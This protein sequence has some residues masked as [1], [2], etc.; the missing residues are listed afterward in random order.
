[1]EQLFRKYINGECTPNEEE[2]VLGKLG[3]KAPTGELYQFLSK[4]WIEIEGKQF[5]SDMDFDSVLD[6]IHHSINLKEADDQKSK[7]TLLNRFYNWTR[8]AAASIIILMA[9]VGVWY[10]GHTGMFQEEVFY[11]VSSVRGQ[12]SSIELPD[13]SK[14]WLNGGSSMVYSSKYGQNSRTIQLKGEGFFKV[15]KDKGVPFLVEAGDVKVTALGTSFNVEA[16]GGSESVTVTLEEG[17]VNVENKVENVVMDPGMQVVVGDTDINVSRVDTRMFTSW[18]SGLLE[19][20][21]EKLTSI[22]SQLA[23]I[24][25]VDFVF[26]T[27]DLK[28]Y[29]YRGAVS[30]DKSILK[31]LEMLRFSTGIKYE[32]KG[33]NILLKK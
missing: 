26:E 18:H 2:Q 20:K 12:S 23:K 7:Y 15:E 8:V 22:T 5:E 19:F 27:E 24:Y 9:S 30:L 17:K 6:K 16:Y 4:Y 3:A 25:D 28:S 29:R 10:S 33:N 32:I 11:T 21:D 13:G 1:M 31:A 14:V